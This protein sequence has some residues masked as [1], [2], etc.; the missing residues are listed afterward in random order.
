M[1]QDHDGVFI[2]LPSKVSARQD[3]VRPFEYTD[4][5]T[6]ETRRLAEVVL[7]RGTEI[8]GQDASFYKFVVSQKQVDPGGQKYKNTH[9]ILQPSISNSTGEPWTV[10]LSRDYGEHDENGDWVP[11]V[12]E[13]RCTS[14]ELKDAAR[15]QYESYKA[16]KAQQRE[17]AE[18]D[19]PS[20]KNEAKEAKEASGKLAAD[21]P[22]PEAPEPTQNR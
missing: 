2:T 7:P 18:K 19:A 20:L 8:S 22:S 15:E 17:A 3:S 1:S 16:Y 11:D 21:A 4:P 9:S 13:I 6:G 10:S 12:K 14:Q 5:E